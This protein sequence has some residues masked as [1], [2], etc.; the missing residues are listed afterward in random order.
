MKTLM[1]AVVCV[2]TRALFAASTWIGGPTVSG[3]DWSDDTKWEG[4][5]PTA[6]SEVIFPSAVTATVTDSEGVLVASFG[7]IRLND[8]GAKMVFNLA[9]DLVCPAMIQGEGS[10][11]KT[12]D[13]ILK[14]DGYAYED[15]FSYGGPGNYNLR[16]GFDILEGG[17]AWPSGKENAQAT[18]GHVR[19]AQGATFYVSTTKATYIGGLSGVGVVTNASATSQTLYVGYPNVDDSD[20]F[21]GIIGG[22]IAVVVSCNQE[23]RGV[24]NTFTG[25]A[26]VRGGAN[27]KTGGVLS[28]VLAGANANEPSSIGQFS[29]LTPTEGGCYRYLGS[30]G[31]RTTKR[32]MLSP[33]GVHAVTMD[34]GPHGGLDFAGEWFNYSGVNQQMGE[35]ILTGTNLATAC[36]F[37]GKFRAEQADTNNCPISTRFTKTG[38]GIWHLRDNA[39]RFNRGV[40]EVNEGRLQYDSIAE[41]GEVCSLGLSTVLGGRY[42]GPWDES[43][44]VDHAIELDGTNAV[45]EFVG[46]NSCGTATRPIGVASAGHVRASGADSASVKLDGA[47]PISGGAEQKTLVLDGDSTAENYMGGV[48]GAISVV[49]SGVGTWTLR[50]DQTFTGDLVVNQGTLKVEK[51]KTFT[52]FR[53]TITAAANQNA[54]LRKIGFYDE[55]GKMINLGMTWSHPRMPQYVTSGT[56]VYESGYVWRNL[57]PGHATYGRSIGLNY[58]SG[59]TLVTF[60]SLFTAGGSAS[61]AQYNI[62]AEKPNDKN[63]W[64]PLVFRMP[65]GEKPAVAFDFA[66]FAS[67][68]SYASV[69]A[70]ILEGSSD[71]EHWYVVA[72]D[73]KFD[74]SHTTSNNGQWIY[75]TKGMSASGSLASLQVPRLLADGETTPLAFTCET[76]DYSVLERV[77]AI[78]V[79]PG[80]TLK[81]EGDFT[82]TITRL[83]VSAT[84]GAGTIDGFALA[85]GAT[86][87][88]VGDYPGGAFTVPVSFAGLKNVST[89]TG[90]TLKV[91]GKTKSGALTLTESSLTFVPAGLMLIFR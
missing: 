81:A 24:N 11:E 63:T 84:T 89:A 87:E 42:Y 8:A 79:A 9:A 17:L 90:L 67:G 44:R 41:K 5:A 88:V 70:Y 78:T 52:W 25:A 53:M 51:R 30:G 6:G 13:G 76:N 60:D 27:G 75:T 12:G 49:K 82:P 80:A 66:P 20:S 56:A 37:S 23:L 22:A 15:W 72:Q 18:Y 54:T 2:L 19:L 69:T 61:F 62:G 91:N 59:S 47:W 28:F 7:K 34:A 14:L 57:E 73:D 68:G 64:C 46:S 55:D 38:S 40:I 85:D 83:G 74:Y 4:G 48:T 31:E 3:T 33:D 32:L 10:M 29:D 86:V 1:L 58:S 45:F 21:D 35:L 36:S 43:K 65:E 39:E 16:G 71:G 77:G 26:K 50:G